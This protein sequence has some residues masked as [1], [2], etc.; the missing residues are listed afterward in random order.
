MA[1]EAQGE[2]RLLACANVAPPIHDR[3]K[4]ARKRLGVVALASL[5]IEAPAGF[6]ADATIL[7]ELGRSEGRIVGPGGG[8]I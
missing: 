6:N 1:A 4:P 8:E 2:A 7:I 3:S 5:S